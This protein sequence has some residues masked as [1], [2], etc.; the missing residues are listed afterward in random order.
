MAQILKKQVRIAQQQA[1]DRLW[2]GVAQ[3]LTQGAIENTRDLCKAASKRA[4]WTIEYHGPSCILEHELGQLV[5][6]PASQSVR[7]L[8]DKEP[9]HTVYGIGTQSLAATEFSAYDLAD[10]ALENWQKEIESRDH[11][12]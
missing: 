9:S 1:D 4:G 5:V 12:P 3:Q 7:L 10:A 8:T 11:R 2:N 6:V